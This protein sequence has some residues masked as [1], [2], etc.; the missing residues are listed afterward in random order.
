[1]TYGIEISNSNGE[2]VIDSEY[3]A[4][5]LSQEV[6]VSGSVHGAAYYY[7]PA[8]VGN[9]PF[10][11]LPVGSWAAFAGTSQNK[12]YYYSD[13]ASITVRSA[14]PINKMPPPDDSY[15]MECFDATGVLTFSTA[16]NLIPILGMTQDLENNPSEGSFSPG[17]EWVCPTASKFELVPFSEDEWLY[18]LMGIKRT[19]TDQM[20]AVFHSIATF[21]A[22]GGGEG[23][24]AVKGIFA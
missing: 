23:G 9:M 14:L 20:D 16:E 4:V 5:Y 21:T 10:F 11:Q 17:A 3:P 2:I 18:R 19:A 15:G 1:M 12:P 8:Q 6:T 24:V 7:T 22:L 13:L